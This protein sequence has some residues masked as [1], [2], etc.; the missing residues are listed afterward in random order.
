VYGPMYAMHVL[1]C[2]LYNILLICTGT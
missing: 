1:F 2:R